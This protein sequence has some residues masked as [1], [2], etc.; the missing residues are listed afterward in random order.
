MEYELKLAKVVLAIAI[1]SGANHLII[2]YLR[3]NVAKLTPKPTRTFI[4]NMF[5][6]VAPRTRS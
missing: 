6:I 1:S 3:R 2:E 4:E 5:E